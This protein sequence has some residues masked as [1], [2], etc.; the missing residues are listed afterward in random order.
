M[1]M[2][3]E[4]VDGLTVITLHENSLEACNIKDFK[5]ELQERVEPRVKVIMD[6]NQVQDVDSAG[7]GA[8]LSLFRQLQLGGGDLKLCALHKRV[9]QLVELIR[10]H[11]IMDVFNTREE[12]IRSYRI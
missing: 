2:S 5:R 10:L 9:R 8:I 4:N 12:A 3:H 11:Q 1:E 7:C 6:L